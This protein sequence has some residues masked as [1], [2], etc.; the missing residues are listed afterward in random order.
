MNNFK[1]DD[2]SFVAY[3]PGSQSSNWGLWAMIQFDANNLIAHTISFIWLC[4]HN[5]TYR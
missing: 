1:S 2:G 4:Y 5:E 3:F